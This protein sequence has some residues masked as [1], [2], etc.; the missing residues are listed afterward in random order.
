MHCQRIARG[1]I[2]DVQGLSIAQDLAH[3]LGERPVVELDARQDEHAIVARGNAKPV[4]V[5]D[6]VVVIGDGQEIVAELAIAGDDLLDG[7]PAIGQRGVGVQVALQRGHRGIAGGGPGGRRRSIRTGDRRGGAISGSE[8]SGRG[9][10]IA[11]LVLSRGHPRRQ[12]EQERTGIA[13]PVLVKSFLS[14]PNLGLAFGLF[15]SRMGN[16]MGQM[17]GEATK[18]GGPVAPQFDV[19]RASSC[20]NSRSAVAFVM[21]STA[22]SSRARAVSLVSA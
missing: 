15:I 12:G 14:R 13:Y 1:V 6:S 7:E 5:G 10:R 21:T 19:K 17:S 11:R 8:W 22:P 20:V 4:V 18:Y 9:R 16:S 3:V 2:E